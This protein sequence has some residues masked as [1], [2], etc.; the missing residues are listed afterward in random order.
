MALRRTADRVNDDVHTY[1]RE[2]GRD[3][4]WQTRERLLACVGPAP[5]SDHVLRSAGRLAAALNAEW[6]T[7]FIETP[8]IQQMPDN[9]R[10]TILARLKLAEDMGSATSSIA[11]ADVAATL[12]AF[13]RKHNITKI[14]LG[15][16]RHRWLPLRA[17]ADLPQRIA[18]LAPDIEIVLVSQERSPGERPARPAPP[19]TAWRRRMRG[20]LSAAGVCAAISLATLPLHGRFQLTNIAMM[21]LLGVLLV[22]MRFGR[23]P[24]IIA[25]L[26]NV[27]AFDLLFVPPRYSFAVA[28]AEYLVTFA[29]MLVVGL[30][31]A[32]VT[33]GFHFQSR[34]AHQ[35]EERVQE[36]YHSARELSGAL[37][38]DQ[39][40]DIAR[41]A[42]Q[43]ML[44]TRAAVLVPDM[45]DR[46]AAAPDAGLAELDL[47]IAQWC[48]DRGAPAGAGTDT[49]PGSAVFYLPLKAPMRVRGVL[50][51]ALKAPFQPEQ[52]RQVEALGALLAI[53]L[54]RVHFVSVAQETLVKIESERLRESLLAAL[55]H[56][57]RTPLTALHGLAEALA[58]QP[59][60]L[61][62]D[63][64]EA[65]EA[66]RVQSLGMVRLVSNLLAMARL[67]SGQTPLRPDWIALEELA[68]SAC[69]VLGSVLGKHTVRIDIPAEFP[70][71]F[72]DAVL[73]ERVLCN[74][75]ENA[76]KYV[77]AGGLIGLTARAVDGTAE[78]EVWDNGPGLPPGR[79][80]AIF[81]KFVRGR[82]ESDTT[83]VGLG[84]AISKAIVEAHRGTIHAANRVEGGARFI[85]RLPLREMPALE[86]EPEL[87]EPA[88]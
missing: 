53:A 73:L 20:A 12:V 55:S 85:V 16:T 4:V 18:A 48:L 47:G 40:V 49:L 67:E 9:A 37:T 19:L 59:E 44:G 71:L 11:N 41:R 24:A 5:G 66:I 77:P 57:L 22:A 30:L 86:A 83:G 2:P 17:R 21:Y 35:R 80:A 81:A 74:L 36:M 62:P 42:I 31:T 54:E 39:I 33:A 46:L 68:G 34:V 56:D 52:R 7:L 23:S 43:T 6:H 88:S 14:V 13:A 51:I 50:A 61:A 84:L 58:Q 70:L 27:L 78:I 45:N 75:L 87:L 82:P 63:Q 25:A 79:E 29:V 38:A 10:Q 8:A 3:R 65:V 32:Q 60:R 15:R 69:R 76:A 26:L 1:R 28:D 72:G 64:A